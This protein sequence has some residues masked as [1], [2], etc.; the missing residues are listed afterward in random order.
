MVSKSSGTVT[1]PFRKPILLFRGGGS[2]GGQP[3][4]RLSCLGD[5]DILASN[6]LFDE[7]REVG[8]GL[9]NVHGSHMG[10]VS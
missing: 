5:D 3:D 2:Q 10:H 8:L 7:L 9:V 4:E 6:S 1:C